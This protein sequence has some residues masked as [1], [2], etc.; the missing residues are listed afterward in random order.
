[1]E[2]V[3]NAGI[4]GNAANAGNAKS[5]C[6]YADYFSSP[7]PRGRRVHFAHSHSTQFAEVLFAEVL[8][9]VASG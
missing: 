1:V 8:S 6:S 9:A 7:S 2:I 5:A 4:A 3:F